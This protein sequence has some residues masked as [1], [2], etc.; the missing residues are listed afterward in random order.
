LVGSFWFPR[1]TAGRVLALVAAGALDLSPLRAETF[2]FD[3]IE[4]AMRASV[5]R[6]GG[7]SHV[8]LVNTN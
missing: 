2:P 8:A 5:E 7:L 1:E 6:S 3:D 4:V